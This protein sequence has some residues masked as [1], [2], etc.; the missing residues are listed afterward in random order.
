MFASVDPH[1]TTWLYRAQ[2]IYFT[3][4]QPSKTNYNIL[5]ETKKKNN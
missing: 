2:M 5:M 1:F 3:R 4:N